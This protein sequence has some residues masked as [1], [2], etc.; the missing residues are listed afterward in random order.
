MQ[1][2]SSKLMQRLA[3]GLAI[4]VLSLSY[5]LGI[6]AADNATTNTT[7]DNATTS[8]STTPNPSPPTPSSQGPQSPTG[9]TSPNGPDAST[10]TYNSTTGLWENAYYTWD[11]VTHVTT[12][13][14]QQTYSY[15][16]KTG[17]WDTTDWVFDAAAGKYVANVKSV[18]KPPGNS[19]AD[20]GPNSKND[21]NSN[22]TTNGF[23]N[24]FY[25]ASISNKLN[26]TATT[27]NALVQA[28]TNAGSGTSGNA[29]DAAN[30][31][32]MLQSSWNIQP[33]IDLMTFT[34]NINGNVNGNLYLDPNAIASTGP[35]S[36]NNINSQNQTNLTVNSKGSGLIDNNLTLGA[37]SGNATV[38]ANT[39][40]G[41]ATSGNAD[42]V[43]NIVNV[44][45]SAITAGKSFLGVI[46]INGNLNGD[47]LLPPNFLDQLISSSAPRATVNLN[48]AKNT[49]VTA[50]L[51]NTETINNNTDLAA[52]SGNA[53]T[54]GNTN[55]GSATTGDSNTN[56]TIFNLT[57]QQVVGKNNL[58]VFVNVLGQWVGL[59]LN[60]PAGANS[61]A[62]CGGS[63]TINSNATNNLAINA[64]SN[65]TINNNLLARSK[66][67]DA[68]VRD[69]T[70][71]GNARS[72]N[73][74]A[75]ANILNL[76]DSHF[77][78][79]DWFGLLFIN[80]LG[81]WHGSFGLKTDTPKTAATAGG[82]DS[83]PNA[84]GQVFGFTPSDQA[85]AKLAGMFNQTPSD[86][87]N[88]QSNQS[89]AAGTTRH[90][91]PAAPTA[92]DAKGFNFMIPLVA[93]LVSA[94]IFGLGALI[95]FS[96]K[97][98]IYIINYK[99]R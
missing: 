41:N 28:N 3:S 65:N 97:L 18:Q 60:A 83:S 12:P 5:P 51:N 64:S 77:N 94:V 58:M 90:R 61:A 39:N 73:A 15:N 78:A 63:C 35:L 31:V 48:A 67:G 23:F 62:F 57:G 91:P 56:L 52:V 27:G 10:F 33:A 71:A 74:S 13:K 6:A 93:A 7:P 80:V 8:S 44:L 17:M 72:G 1:I 70:V 55:A 87:N 37:T 68:M 85:T 95:E 32:N 4:L 29:M 86:A 21:V 40:G 54:S 42:A 59:I 76:M 36:T 2:I 38:A 99:L 96:D 49:N 82:T 14:S 24:N 19:I 22:S 46:N 25:D 75:S 30:I 50:N 43:A 53:T 84:P 66:T 9:Q 34:A 69:N 81:V 26:Q 11:P 16:P 88:S 92:A 98:R 45:N 79:S 20:T 47:I 89:V